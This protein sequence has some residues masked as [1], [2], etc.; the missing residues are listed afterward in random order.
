MGGSPRASLC[1]RA[2]C[3]TLVLPFPPSCLLFPNDTTGSQLLGREELQRGDGLT[4]KGPGDELDVV[5]LDVLDDHDLCL[6]KKVEGKIGEG[7]SENGLLHQEHVAACLLDLFDHFNHQLSLLSEE[8]VHRLVISDLDV[9]LQIRLRGRETKLDQPNLCVLDPGGPAGS[10]GDPLV[11]EHEAVHEL[12]VFHSCASLFDDSDIV[13]V[14]LPGSG[15]I[16]YLHDCINCQRSQHVGRL[17]DDLGGEGRCCVVNQGVSVC[18]VHLFRHSFQNFLCLRGRGQESLRYDLGVDALV[19]ER[20]A[21][22]QK[23][24]RKHHHRGSAVSSLYVLGL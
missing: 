18:Q 22:V 2:H 21:D 5:S 4:Q 13:Q 11:D 24:T 23:G 1:T 10:L 20:L 15:R 6:R 14:N 9:V 16:V 7:V 3:G 12:R 17:S 19:E 8:S